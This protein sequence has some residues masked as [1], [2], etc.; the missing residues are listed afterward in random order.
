MK[1]IIEVFTQSDEKRTME[2]IAIWAWMILSLFALIFSLIAYNQSKNRPAPTIIE[3][4]ASAPPAQNNSQQ[5]KLREIRSSYSSD[6]VAYI[7]QVITATDEQ[8]NEATVMSRV[9]WKMKSWE[10]VIVQSH[11]DRYVDTWEHLGKLYCGHFVTKEDIS[12]IL[13]SS[14]RDVCQNTQVIN[15]YA[16]TKPYFARLCKDIITAD[17]WMGSKANSTISCISG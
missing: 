11:L 16:S 5:A 9:R 6:V 8:K 15:N 10:N 2:L 4:V 17:S 14:L 3:K 12:R 13:I 1:E 7:R